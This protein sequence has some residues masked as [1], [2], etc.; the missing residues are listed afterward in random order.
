M[1]GDPT[2]ACA[3]DAIGGSLVAQF[4]RERI[5]SRDDIPEVSGHRATGR[6]RD[7]LP[8]SG[9]GKTD[10]RLDCIVDV[11]VDHPRIVQQIVDVEIELNRFGAELAALPGR[12]RRALHRPRDLSNPSTIRRSSRVCSGV[13]PQQE[14]TIPAPAASASGTAR[15]VSTGNCF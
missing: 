2:G 3:K 14:P 6:R 9:T 11:A 13:L 15:A 7:V 1:G 5:I 12:P 8:D 10:R 4:R